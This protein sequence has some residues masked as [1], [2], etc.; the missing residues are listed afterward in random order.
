M[1]IRVAITISVIH[2]EKL[3][4]KT[5]SAERDCEAE[6]RAGFHIAPS[7]NHLHGHIISTNSGNSNTKP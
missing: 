6:I 1:E 2:L 7:I 5:A 4:G 3:H